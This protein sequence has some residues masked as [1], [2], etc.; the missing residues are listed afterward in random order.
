M[1]SRQ[2]R[3]RR[4]LGVGTQRPKAAVVAEA[5]KNTGGRLHR[6]QGARKEE[7]EQL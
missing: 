7:T 1:P 2:D 3:N 5:P 6:V 4:E